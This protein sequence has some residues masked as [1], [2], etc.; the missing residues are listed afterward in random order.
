MKYEKLNLDPILEGKVWLMQKKHSAIYEP[1]IHRELEFNLVL[2]GQAEYIVKGV[3]FNLSPN[4]LIWLFPNQKH[5]LI[6]ASENFQMYIAVFK[7]NF[8]KQLV[9][10]GADKTLISLDYLENV[11]KIIKEDEAK[12]FILNL[13]EIIKIKNDVAYYN[14][15]LATICLKIWSIF[16][17]TEINS[18]PNKF[19]EMIEKCLHLLQNPQSNFTLEGFSE[20]LGYSPSQIS[21]LFKKHTGLSIVDY[22]NQKRLDYVAI[23][24]NAEKTTIT[25]AAYEAGFG[26]YAQFHR[27]FKLHFGYSPN[28]FIR[29]LKSK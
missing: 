6:N 22:R 20:E 24:M 25:K 23:K 2:S 15:Y 21:R 19:P 26:S 10:K 5:V 11:P 13:E 4:T 8:L 3:K 16:K 27:I 14:S 9:G 18:I 7:P 28:E 12:S 17:K 1:H 29:K